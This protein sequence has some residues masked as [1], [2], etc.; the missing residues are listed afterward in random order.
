MPQDGGPGVLALQGFLLLMYPEAAFQ[1][2]GHGIVFVLTGV[3][4]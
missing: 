1:C 4:Q 2:R 3:G